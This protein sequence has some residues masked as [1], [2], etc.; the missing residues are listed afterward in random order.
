MCSRTAG[1]NTIDEESISNLGTEGHLQQGDENISV[2]PVVGVGSISGKSV[3]P[4]A[5]IKAETASHS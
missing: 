4:A 2:R 3:P 5:T 1:R